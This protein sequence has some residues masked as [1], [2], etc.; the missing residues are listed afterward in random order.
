MGFWSQTSASPSYW[1][2]WIS[3]PRPRFLR[4]SVA[5]YPRTPDGLGRPRRLQESDAAELAKFWRTHYGGS[6][7]YLD[8]NVSFVLRYIRNPHV[9]IFGLFTNGIELIG[10]IVSTPL[11]SGNTHMSHGP[12]MTTLRVIEGLCVH[13]RFRSKGIA[14]YLIGCMDAFTSETAPVAHLWGRE[15]SQTPFMSTAIRTDTYA[16]MRCSRNDSPISMIPF[17]WN[18]F[19]GLW[20]VSS[21]LW[22]DSCV[23]RIVASVPSAV[24]GHHDVWILDNSAKGVVPIIVVTN[25][26]RK[27]RAE[28]RCIYEIAWCGYLRENH[29]VPADGSLEFKGWIE[30][31]AS[32][33]DGILF[34][35]SA[36]TNG[37][38]TSD[39]KTPWVFGSSGVHAWYLYNYVPPAFGR[40]ELLTIRDEL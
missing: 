4:T 5:E 14:G 13:P 12:T 22:T 33:Y 18:D 36:L 19:R 11:T 3:R 15:L 23:S 6:D 24:H 17:A 28:N 16:Y 35:S 27:T 34:V 30:E 7:W 38:A 25:T 2:T 31:I 10:T 1:E 39:W 37:G 32:Q 8:C 21:H 9:F 20:M 26:H 29:L 40:C